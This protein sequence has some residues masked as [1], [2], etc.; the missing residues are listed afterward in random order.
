MKR[1]TVLDGLVHAPFI[2]AQHSQERSVIYAAGVGKPAHD[3][4]DEGGMCDRFAERRRLAVLEIGMYAVEIAGKASKIDDVGARDRAP[5]RLDNLPDVEILEMHAPWFS[6]HS[7]APRC[8]S[9]L[10]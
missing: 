8:L 6:S 1:I 3:C 5:W 2:D 4:V 10:C 7:P 9:C